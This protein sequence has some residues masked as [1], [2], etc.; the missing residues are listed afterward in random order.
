VE[1]GD[2]DRN[3]FIIAGGQSGNPLSPHY[4]DQ[5][6]LWLEGKTIRIA[7]SEE[8]IAGRTKE[9]LVLLPDPM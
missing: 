2:W 4:D 8:A 3:Y 1:V 6:K 5:L 9:T 7:W